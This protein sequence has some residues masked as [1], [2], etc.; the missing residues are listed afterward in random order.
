MLGTRETE[1]PS[2]PT[3]EPVNLL[4]TLWYVLRCSKAYMDMSVKCFSFHLK[5]PSIDGL[6]SYTFLYRE[7]K[8]N[9]DPTGNLHA[10]SWSC[11][12]WELMPYGSWC[13]NLSLQFFGVWWSEAWDGQCCSNWV[14]LTEVSLSLAATFFSLLCA[15]LCRENLLC[16]LMFI[17]ILHVFTAHRRKWQIEKIFVFT[18]A[19]TLLQQTARQ[20]QRKCQSLSFSTLCAMYMFSFTCLKDNRKFSQYAALI[21]AVSLHED[22]PLHPIAGVWNITQKGGWNHRHFIYPCQLNLNKLKNDLPATLRG[23]QQKITLK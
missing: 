7:V 17:L 8:S 23:I 20:T 5:G 12:T 4:P 16:P 21:T 2:H 6:T 10:E 15:A 22:Y 14:A 19:K 3:K 9:T 13:V 11:S 18:K 1:P